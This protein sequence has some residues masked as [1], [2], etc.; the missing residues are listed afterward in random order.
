MAGTHVVSACLAPAEAVQLDRKRFAVYRA[1]EIREIQEEEVTRGKGAEYLQSQNF[2]FVTGD[3]RPK[4]CSV[5]ERSA[6]LG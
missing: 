2:N 5:G 4:L 3:M 1:Q 6:A